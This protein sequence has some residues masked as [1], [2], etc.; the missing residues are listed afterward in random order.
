MATP[1]LIHG[2]AHDGSCWDRLTPGSEAR[3]HE[4]VTPDLPI[5]DD[6]AGLDV[7]AQEAVDAIGD[8]GDVVVVA[9]SPG[10]LVAPVVRTKTGRGRSWR[11]QS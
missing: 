11:L 8:R 7:H 4:V 3:S 6:A 5:D 9:H 2:G 10:G 1:A